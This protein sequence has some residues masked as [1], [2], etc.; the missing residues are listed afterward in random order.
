MTP[1]SAPSDQTERPLRDGD[2]IDLRVY[3]SALWRARLLVLGVTLVAAAAAAGWSLMAPRQYKASMTIAVGQSKLSETQQTQVTPASFIPLLRSRS[4]G[5][6]L[7]REFT[8][9]QPPHSLNASRL[10]QGSVDASDVRN[11]NLISVSV[12]LRDAELA[13]RVA[14]RLAELAVQT[15]GTI[16]EDEG[17]RARDLVKQQ[18][19]EAKRKFD[20][21]TTRYREY[22]ERAQVEG[23]RKDIEALLGER[24]GLLELR[25][26]IEALKAKLARAE[27]ELGGRTRIDTVSRSIDTDPAMMEASKTVAAPGDRTVLGLKMENEFVNPVYEQLD[28]TVASGRVEL[29]ELERRL[30]QLATDRKVDA[31]SLPQLTRLYE[32][33]S[34]LATLEV[35]LQIARAG[36]T[37]LAE[38]YELV[39]L[40]VAGRSTWLTVIDPPVAPD[41]PESRH[42]ARNTVLA[43]LL[44]FLL[45]VA[46]ITVVTAGKT[47]A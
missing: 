43:G 11:T 32:H 42:V 9:D 18:L 10:V 12:T 7:I 21:A 31:L 33:E 8:L 44:A 40:D 6:T 39:R 28:Q 3:L 23:L 30:A 36:Y 17:A 38:R 5:Q 34:A 22:R 4:V 47:L 27:Q 13:A 35:E 2:G 26:R 20:E 14:S 19:D 45:S 29:A 46:A 37:T 16:T 1:I 15:A 25:V 24:G 41:L